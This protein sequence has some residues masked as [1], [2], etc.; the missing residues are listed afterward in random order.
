MY[1]YKVVYEEMGTSAMSP[2]LEE[3]LNKWA[4]EGWR[5]VAG[6]GAGSGYLPVTLAVVLERKKLAPYA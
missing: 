6:G 1:E 2:S 5:V 3:E 4:A